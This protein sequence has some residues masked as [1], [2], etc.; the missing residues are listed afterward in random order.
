LNAL[1]DAANARVLYAPRE[2]LKSASG[3][4]TLGRLILRLLPSCR[5][6]KRHWFIGRVFGRS[7]RAFEVRRMFY[8]GMT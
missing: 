7:R 5:R 6:S 4:W 1:L 8:R 3:Y 2:V